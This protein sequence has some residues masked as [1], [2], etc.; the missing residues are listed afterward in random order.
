M[1]VSYLGTGK[2]LWC[3]KS[4]VRFIISSV[5]STLFMSLRCCLSESIGVFLASKL[6]NPAISVAVDFSFIEIVQMISSLSLTSKWMAGLIVFI[7]QNSFTDPKA[8][9]NLLGF[10]VLPLVRLFITIVN[11]INKNDIAMNWQDNISTLI[12]RR[13]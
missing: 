5:I 8:N 10:L 9:Y 13:N 3:G 4:R 6:F 11:M 2:E 12:I 7:G 1:Y